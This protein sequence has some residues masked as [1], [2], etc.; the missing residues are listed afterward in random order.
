MRATVTGGGYYLLA[1]DGGVFNYGD[2]SF[3][4]SV[5]GVV[6]V[7]PAPKVAMATTQTR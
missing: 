3:Y 1:R 4:G 6:R 2:A 5:P 7:S